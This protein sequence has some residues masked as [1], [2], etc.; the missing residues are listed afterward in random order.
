MKQI[1]WM[2]FTRTQ[3]WLLGAILLDRDVEKANWVWM[4]YNNNFATQSCTIINASSSQNIYVGVYSSIKQQ[5][6]LFIWPEMNYKIH[7]FDKI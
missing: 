7:K 5:K 6:L 3:K 4:K 2:Q 1:L